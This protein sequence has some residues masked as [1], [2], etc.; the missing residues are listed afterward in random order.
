MTTSPSTTA[1]KTSRPNVRR[2]AG[3]GGRVVKTAITGTA[4]DILLP[5]CA[6]AH[7]L[8]TEQLPELRPYL[9]HRKKINFSE[10]Q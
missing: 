5:L 4:R 8:N 10:K 1:G 9:P 7:E 3:E 2:G 6:E